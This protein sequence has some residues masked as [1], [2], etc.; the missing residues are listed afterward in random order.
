[1]DLLIGREDMAGKDS[2]SFL[3]LI[4]ALYLSLVLHLL[5]LHSRVGEGA[6][7]ACSDS[8]DFRVLDLPFCSDFLSIGGANTGILGHFDSSCGPINLQVVFFQPGESKYKVLFPNAG[9]CK[10]CLF[11]MSVIPEHQLYYFS[12]WASLIQ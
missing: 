5:Y 11:V 1:M 2:V 12:D 4:S 9:D 3:I 10:H 8:T 7:L 6:R